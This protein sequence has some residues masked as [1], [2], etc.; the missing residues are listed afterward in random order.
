M[1]DK[2]RFGST[3]MIWAFTTLMVIIMVGNASLGWL[4]SWVISVPLG[5]A[6]LATALIWGSAV[7]VALFSQGKPTQHSQP[8]QKGDSTPY[9]LAML[10]EMMTEEERE[11]FKNRL[12]DNL[13]SGD[14]SLSLEDLAGEKRKRR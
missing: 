10:L 6:F 3:V 4:E 12:K 11:D 8:T 2:W 9:K 5:V 1:N 13:L 7:G 14:E